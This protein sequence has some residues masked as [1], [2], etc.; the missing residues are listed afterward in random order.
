MPA[1]H[2][3]GG[4]RPAA[5]VGPAAGEGTALRLEEFSAE[6]RRGLW[7]LRAV[8]LGLSGGPE[9]PGRWRAARSVGSTS[10]APCGTDGCDPC[11]ASCTAERYARAFLTSEGA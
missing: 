4:A 7:G 10:A 1:E 11:Q 2:G 6:L 3:G 5:G 8:G 9:D